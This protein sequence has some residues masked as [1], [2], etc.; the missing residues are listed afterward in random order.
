MM[1]KLIAVC[2]LLIS[3]S[4]LADSFV[5]LTEELPP[6]S[7]KKGKQAEGA[8]V[9]IVS[10][11][12]ERAGFDYSVKIAPWKR[13]YL[14]TQS[15]KNTCVFPVQRSQ[16]REVLFHWVS[17]VVITQTAFYTHKDSS[18]SIRTIDDVKGLKIGSYRGSNAADYLIGQGYE[19]ALTARDAP[20]IQKLA[21]KR[22]DVWAA[23]TITSKYLMKQNSIETIKEQLV[24]FT[25]L[26]AL[27]CNLDTPIEAI[28][29]LKVE[30]KGMYRDGSIEAIMAGYR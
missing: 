8:T 30:L 1:N 9:E 21:N 25:A 24:Y 29:K 20:N 14:S 12:F 5:L 2:L 11:L 17:P 28:E 18:L 19:L 26:R 4:L 13:A 15:N 6:Y 22:I 3:T 27:A 10:K 16:E 23:D 7:M